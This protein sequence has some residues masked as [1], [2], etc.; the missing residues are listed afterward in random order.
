VAYLMDARKPRMDGAPPQLVLGELYVAAVDGGAPRKVGEAVVNT[1]GAYL[2]GPDER[3]VFALQGFNLASQSGQLVALDLSNPSS[4]PRTLGA[5]VSYVLPSPDG[6]WLAFV[7]GGVLR[8]AQLPEGAPVDVS[9]EV[10]DATFARDSSFLLVKRRVSAAAGLLYVPTGKWKEAKKLAEQVGDYSISPDSKN[11][12]FAQRSASLPGTYDLLHASVPAL[13]VRTLARGVTSGAP[14]YGSSFA[15]SPDGKYLARTEDGRPER[16]G[17]L[18]VGPA[19]GEPGRKVADNVYQFDF[20]PDSSALAYLDRY[21]DNKGV[22]NGHGHVGVV[23]LPDGAP[24]DLGQRVPNYNWGADGKYLA[25]VSRIFNPVYSVDLML[26]RAGEPS[27]VKVQEGVFG[28]D[29]TVGNAYLLMRTRCIREGRSCELHA[30]DLS[31]PGEAPKKILDAVYTFHSAEDPRRVVA[32]Y[33]R[34]DSPLY[35]AMALNIAT[36]QYTSLDQ[37]VQLPVL[38]AAKDGR[39][40]AYVV[41]EPRRAGVYVAREVP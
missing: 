31:K 36:G 8:V 37:L 30:L 13:D 41:G 11:V 3:Y 27:A 17:N 5:A 1:P 7:D 24:R 22:H 25:F 18:V 2:F 40:V 23:A 33:A 9:G 10:A 15:F 6:K 16:R 39:K 29:F 28:Y 19:G 35:D 14:S 12:A 21:S 32:T 20:A 34:V 38:F 26:Y 4:S